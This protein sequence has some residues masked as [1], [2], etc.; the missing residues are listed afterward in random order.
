ML[1]CFFH[2]FR[3]S[4]MCSSPLELFDVKTHLAFADVSLDS[5]SNP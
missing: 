5:L 2:F 3:L 4:E 1:L